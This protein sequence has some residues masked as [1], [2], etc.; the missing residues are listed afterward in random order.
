MGLSIVCIYIEEQAE[1]KKALEAIR[2]YSDRFEPVFKPFKPKLNLSP[3]DAHMK[4]KMD[5]RKH[6][7]KNMRFCEVCIREH[8]RL[9][10]TDLY[11][12]MRQMHAGHAS[13]VFMCNICYTP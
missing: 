7:E 5:H 2:E 10:P 6:E 11:Q 9:I 8:K 12:K 1:I 13:S 3:G 4:L